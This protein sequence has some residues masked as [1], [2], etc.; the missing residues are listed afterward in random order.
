[1]FIALSC[2]IEN[3]F[4]RNRTKWSFY[5]CW[6][7]CLVG[8]SSLSPHRY[9]HLSPCHWHQWQVLRRILRILEKQEPPLPWRSPFRLRL[10]RFGKGLVGF[11]WQHEKHTRMDKALGAV[12]EVTCQQ[13]PLVMADPLAGG[14]LHY[15]WHRSF[16]GRTVV[17]EPTTST[18][19]RL[20]F[21]SHLHTAISLLLS[22]WLHFWVHSY[23]V[24]KMV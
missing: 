11:M 2:Y 6:W 1:M 21:M 3:T 17:P 9:I 12:H 19:M 5:L 22:Q 24:P 10:S 7:L 15:W 20:N 4:H 8:E 23:I 16:L 14:R 13:W 18:V